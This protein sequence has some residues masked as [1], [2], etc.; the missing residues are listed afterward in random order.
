[1][2]KSAAAAKMPKP[3]MLP[4]RKPRGHPYQAQKSAQPAKLN[5]A[6]RNEKLILL[7]LRFV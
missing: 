3:A 2:K 5:A 1:M 4:P 6:S 7:I